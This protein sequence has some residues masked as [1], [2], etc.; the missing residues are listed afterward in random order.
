MP[1]WHEF[2]DDLDRA[3]DVWALK[4]DKPARVTFEQ[5]ILSMI[6]GSVPR[7]ELR[8]LCATWPHGRFGG[9]NPWND[10]DMEWSILCKLP[11]PDA[12]TG[13]VVEA[14]MSNF[15]PVEQGGDAGSSA[16]SNLKVVE[17]ALVAFV[18][19]LKY[20]MLVTAWYFNRN[21]REFMGTLPGRVQE[22]LN[23][24]LWEAVLKELLRP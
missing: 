14:L 7:A 11:A 5:A 8:V 3:E 15:H 16:V 23:A 2:W 6:R 18:D 22:C 1:Q 13:D 9:D 17:T 10:S 20:S 19:R 21:S 4:L 24:Y 12:P